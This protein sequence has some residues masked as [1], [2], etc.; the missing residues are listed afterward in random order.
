MPMVITLLLLLMLI[1][2]FEILGIKCIKI[3]L[4][5]LHCPVRNCIKLF[6]THPTPLQVWT[7][8]RMLIGSYY[9]HQP[10]TL[11]FAFLIW[12]SK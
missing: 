9:R 8:G 1:S 3:R 7:A 11:L 10:F 5:C 6:R 12:W 2:C 4:L